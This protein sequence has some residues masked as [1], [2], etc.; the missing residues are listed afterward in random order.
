MDDNIDV[1]N[2]IPVANPNPEVRRKS[3]NNKPT[4][5]NKPTLKYDKKLDKLQELFV[6]ILL[7]KSKIN[8]IRIS[9]EPFVK[10]KNNKPFILNMP[11]PKPKSQPNKLKKQD[12]SSINQQDNYRGRSS[13]ISQNKPNGTWGSRNASSSR[14]RSRSRSRSPSK[15]RYRQKKNIK[16]PNRFPSQISQT[17]QSPN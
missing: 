8:E 6:R 9:N 1:E 15:S 10:N 11:K 17:L 13:Y 3:E 5:T 12:N 2:Q 4:N 7:H 14:S 16:Q